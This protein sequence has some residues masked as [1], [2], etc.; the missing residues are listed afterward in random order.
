MVCVWTALLTHLICLRSTI[1][2]AKSIHNKSRQRLSQEAYRRNSRRYLQQKGSRLASP[3]RNSR[4]SAKSPLREIKNQGITVT[5][6]DMRFAIKTP[7]GRGVIS[8][9]VQQITSLRCPVLALRANWRRRLRSSPRGP[10]PSS[11]W[12]AAPTTPA[13]G[14]A[15]T[16]QALNQPASSI[17]FKMSK[18]SCWTCSSSMSF[19][20]FL[21]HKQTGE[22]PAPFS[23][24]KC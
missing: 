13:R 20:S 3:H 7:K 6:S 17:E 8:V 19:C 12:S 14:S 4:N 2:N 9:S 23:V 10:A 18:L 11:S 24:Q 1:R 22:K 5:P 16:C 21:S 15:S